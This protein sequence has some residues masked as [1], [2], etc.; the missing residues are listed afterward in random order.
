MLYVF[1][2]PSDRAAPPRR[3]PPHAL[4]HKL[5]DKGNTVLV[6]EHDPDVI[7]IAD[8]VVD[9]GPRAGTHGGQVVFE[10][11]VAGPPRGRHPHR[12]SSCTG[13]VPIK[14]TSARPTG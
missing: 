13:R 4:L 14:D 3:R 6:V 9:I 5:R 10:G 7:A 8:H 11:S 12:P 1:D 2:E